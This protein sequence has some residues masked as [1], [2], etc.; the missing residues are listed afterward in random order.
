MQRTRAELEGMHHDELVT[1]VLEL[2][3]MLKEGLAV[4]DALHGVMNTLLNAKADEVTRYAD[5]DDDDLAHD[6]VEIKRAW[7]A[8]RHA[9]SNPLGLMHTRSEEER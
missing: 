9:V 5:A 3:D 7:A 4:R 2:Q 6:E 1:R 8:A